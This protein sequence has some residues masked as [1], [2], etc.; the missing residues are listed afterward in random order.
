VCRES[1]LLAAMEK[2]SR[3]RP[4]EAFSCAKAPP[5]ERPLEVLQ[6]V[7][8]HARQ[9][10][11]PDQACFQQS[12]FGQ[13]ALYQLVCEGVFPS[14]LLVSLDYFCL[15]KHKSWN[16]LVQAIMV[17]C[18]PA[19]LEQV[20]VGLR[21]K[22]LRL[23][24]DPVGYKVLCRICEHGG[25]LTQ[26]R[27]LLQ[28]LVEVVVAAGKVDV[29]VAYVLGKAIGRLEDFPLLA[30]QL[31][32]SVLP[33]CTSPAGGWR[34]LLCRAVEMGKL[35]PAALLDTDVSCVSTHKNSRQL[36]ILRWARG[37]ALSSKDGSP[38]SSSP[39][40][41]EEALCCPT[42]SYLFCRN[43]QGEET[44]VF[45]HYALF[46]LRRLTWSIPLFDEELFRSKGLPFLH[47][48]LATFEGRTLSATLIRVCEALKESFFVQVRCLDPPEP[49]LEHLV[50]C[51]PGAVLPCSFP[52][53]ADLA[54]PFFLNPSLF[55]MESG[56]EEPVKKSLWSLLVLDPRELSQPPPTAEP[57]F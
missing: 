43:E 14:E 25:H 22:S 2:S 11:L 39:S 41:G 54:K 17:V 7:L 34:H 31:R 36:E 1:V 18:P 50:F 20:C 8:Q 10:G 29:F 33:A 52:L 44:Y 57:D 5:A 21:G 6:S 19:F 28:E 15:A 48:G 51:A 47:L 30:R 32:R 16:F 46:A 38:A 26:V 13:K 35:P 4:S 3:V 40:A 53:V 23:S 9:G 24:R 56:G 12:V 27:K 42:A 49:S 37:Q 45:S 55:V